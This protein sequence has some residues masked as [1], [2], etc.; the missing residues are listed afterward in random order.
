MKLAT[1]LLLG[2]TS[3]LSLKQSFVWDE[4]EALDLEKAHAEADVQNKKDQIV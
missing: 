3:A 4:K 2:S 1:L